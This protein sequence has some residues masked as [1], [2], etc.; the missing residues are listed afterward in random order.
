MYG[1]SSIAAEVL[2]P[3]GKQGL[4]DETNESCI[5]ML[6]VSICKDVTK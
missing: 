2:A 1:L 3:Q 5:I 4:H 6:R